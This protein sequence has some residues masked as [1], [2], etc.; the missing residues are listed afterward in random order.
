MGSSW[1]AAQDHGF[2]DNP[3]SQGAPRIEPHHAPK[4]SRD[5]GQ[6]GVGSTQPFGFGPQPALALVGPGTFTNFARFQTTLPM[7]SSQIAS[8]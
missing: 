5:N 7:Y 1:H 8:Y 4:V 6:L 3:K 2:L